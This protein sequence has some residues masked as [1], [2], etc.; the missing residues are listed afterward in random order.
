[1]PCLCGLRAVAV[2]VNGVVLSERE[3]AR[4]A[5]GVRGARGVNRGSADNAADEPA[6]VARRRRSGTDDM[7]ARVRR[8]KKQSARAVRGFSFDGNVRR[9]LQHVTSIHEVHV[10]SVHYSKSHDSSG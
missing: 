4:E 10:D 7:L 9:D 1:M 2:A 3:T 8:K 6:I 5:R